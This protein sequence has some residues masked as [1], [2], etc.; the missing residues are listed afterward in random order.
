MP[1]L[2]VIDYSRTWGLCK[3]YRLHLPVGFEIMDSSYS[4]SS[5]GELLAAGVSFLVNLI[6]D[7]V[8]TL[9]AKDVVLR[10]CAKLIVTD[11]VIYAM[12]QFI[13]SEI[14][15]DI[16]ADMFVSG[17]IEEASRSCSLP[18]LISEARL[19]YLLR[20]AWYNSAFYR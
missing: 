6:N 19:D 7:N 16:F 12:S 15:D 8:A 17:V 4:S 3:Q 2:Y 10:S 9:F 14:I 11:V 1:D 18:D 13:V 5:T 20:R